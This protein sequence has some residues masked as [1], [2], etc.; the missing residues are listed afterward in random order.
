MQK[1]I[2]FI[3]SVMLLGACAEMPPAWWNPRGTTGETPK[4]TTTAPA[5][6]PQIRQQTTVPVEMDLSLQ[7]ETY[8][9]MTLTPLQDEE[10]ENESGD[11]SAQSVVPPEDEDGLPPPSILTE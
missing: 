4:T 6:K 3:F 2:S 8:E 11:A 5:T 10:E 7:D 1:V 9:E